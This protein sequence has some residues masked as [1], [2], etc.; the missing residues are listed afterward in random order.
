MKYK[1]IVLGI[2]L[3]SLILAAST[4]YLQ[5]MINYYGKK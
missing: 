5:V 3:V 1:D 4:V 2:R